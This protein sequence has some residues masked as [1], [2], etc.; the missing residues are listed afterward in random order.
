MRKIKTITVPA[1]LLATMILTSCAGTYM[2][3]RQPFETDLGPFSSFVFSVESNV[4]DDVTK[5]MA[6]LEERVLSK[7]K[8]LN[9]FQNVELGDEPEPTQG[10]L[11]VTATITHIKKVSGMTRF[12]LGVF[13]GKASMT[14]DV[15]FLD[16]AT[17]KAIGS[18]S[19]TGESGGTG[20]SGGTSDAVEKTAEGIAGLISKNYKGGIT[21]K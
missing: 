17:G 20:L 13:A 8:S 10:K 18:F 12:F 21:E 14:T 11:H 6:D 1:L 5:E 3:L 19:V 7:V 9:L 16:A 15:I 2:T 4:T